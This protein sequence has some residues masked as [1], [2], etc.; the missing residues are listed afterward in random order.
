MNPYGRCMCGQNLGVVPTTF[1]LTRTVKAHSRQA[2]QAE[3]R[4]HSA[5]TEVKSIHAQSFPL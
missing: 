2:C 1:N 5:S 3:E 4:R